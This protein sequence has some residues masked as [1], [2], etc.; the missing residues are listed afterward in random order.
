MRPALVRSDVPGMTSNSS[1]VWPP[2]LADTVVREEWEQMDAAQFDT[3]DRKYHADAGGTVYTW[4]AG[5]GHS[6]AVEIVGLEGRPFKG[7]TYINVTLQL[8]VHTQLT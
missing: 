8:K 4:S 2:V 5:D 7:N 3:F 1:I 6:Y